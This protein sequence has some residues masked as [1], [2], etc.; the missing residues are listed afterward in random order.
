MNT[1]H[2]LLSH[3]TQSLYSAGSEGTYNNVSGEAQVWG[4]PLNVL[5]FIL[6]LKLTKVHC[7]PL[8]G[9]NLKATCESGDHSKA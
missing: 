4:L 9:S 8:P 6:S 3:I 1:S 7:I 5:K 2:G